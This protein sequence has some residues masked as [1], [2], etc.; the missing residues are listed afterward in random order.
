MVPVHDVGVGSMLGFAQSM[1]G[2]GVWSILGLP[3]VTGVLVY[4][5]CWFLCA[6]CDQASKQQQLGP[7]EKTRLLEQ[8]KAIRL[9]Q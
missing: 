1:F 7:R 9:C 8:K 2:V 4:G 6:V 5:Q 3:V